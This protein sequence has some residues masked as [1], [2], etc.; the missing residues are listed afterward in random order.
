MMDDYSFNWWEREKEK[1]LERRPVCEW[2]GQ[3]IQDEYMYQID[4]EDVCQACVDDW[5]RQCKTMIGG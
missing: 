1:E 5:L 3:P 4:N 2:C